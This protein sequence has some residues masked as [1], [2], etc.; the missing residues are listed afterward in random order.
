MKRLILLFIIGSCVA[1][2]LAQNE[3]TLGSN[4]PIETSL[5]PYVPRYIIPDKPTTNWD[6]NTWGKDKLDTRTGAVWF[7]YPDPNPAKVHLVK[8][9]GGPNL[10]ENES[11]N[12]RFEISYCPNGDRSFFILIDTKTGDTW[13]G[14]KGK[15]T[16]VE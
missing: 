13:H 12:G 15:L 5:S 14:H 11:Y 1:S 9:E 7:I 2:C 6:R 8:Y 10:T 16:R 4:P 3:A